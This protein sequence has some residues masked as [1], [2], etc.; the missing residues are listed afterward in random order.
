MRRTLKLPELYDVANDPN[1]HFPQYVYRY[2]P[3]DEWDKPYTRAKYTSSGRLIPGPDSSILDAYHYELL[4]KVPDC[5]KHKLELAWTEW[6]RLGKY[7]NGETQRKDLFYTSRDWALRWVLYQSIR[8]G[9]A[10]TRGSR[11]AFEAKWTSMALQEM[12][13]NSDW[14]MWEEIEELKDPPI[15]ATRRVGSVVDAD[16]FNPQNPEH[17]LGP[18]CY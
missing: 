3:E 11:R 6:R 13:D 17:A 7:Q 18:R 1:P 8:E 4:L 15:E 2:L 16:Y 12:E 5:D 9:L 10:G 14:E